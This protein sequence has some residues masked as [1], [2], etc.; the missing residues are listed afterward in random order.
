MREESWRITLI[1]DL[2]WGVS[3][4]IWVS[5]W[6][7]VPLDDDDDNTKHSHNL[8]HAINKHGSVYACGKRSTTR[9]KVNHSLQIH[10]SVLDYSSYRLRGIFYS[11]TTLFIAFEIA[12]KIEHSLCVCVCVKLT[13]LSN[14]H[15][16][17]HTFTHH[18]R[19]IRSMHGKLIRLTATHTYQNDMPFNWHS[20][21]ANFHGTSIIWLIYQ[22]YNT[23]DVNR[24]GIW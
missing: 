18:Q 6:V 17:S 16:L 21:P 4:C 2:K 9:W 1:N 22:I 19:Q 5:E 14:N 15:S 7:S 23:T 13:L 8:W 11:R 24:V 12:R 10:E 20:L 3:V